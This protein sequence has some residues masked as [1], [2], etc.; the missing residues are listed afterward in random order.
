[1][2]NSSPRVWEYSSD[3]SALAPSFSARRS[4]QAGAEYSFPATIT[5][6]SD[7]ASG[8]RPPFSASASMCRVDARKNTPVVAPPSTCVSVNLRPF[9]STSIG[10]SGK[11]PGTDA[12]ASRTVRYS[13]LA[14]GRP[15][16]AIAPMSQITSRRVS[17]FVVPTSSR[18]RVPSR[19]PG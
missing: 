18:R 8:C 1:M 4:V 2:R 13:S 16:A 19:R 9:T 15:L 12:D 7:P 11:N 5:Y 6:A 17:M 3:S 10:T 14:S